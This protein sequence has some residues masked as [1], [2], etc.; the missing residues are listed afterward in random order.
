MDDK[1]KNDD[2]IRPLSPEEIKAIGEIE[3]GP[4][5]HEL[6]LNAHYKKLLWC[7]IALS[8]GAGS[9]IAWFSY[10]NDHR[11]AA[12]AQVINVFNTSAPG[13]AAAPGA[14]SKD[15]L[16]ALQQNYS[17]TPSAATGKLLAALSDLQG[18][19]AEAALAA[20]QQIADSAES[21]LIAARAQVAVANYY[22]NNSKDKEASAAWQKLVQMGDSPYL[23]LAYL[24]LGDLASAAG[25]KKAARTYYESARSKC[26][27]SSLVAGSDKVVEMRLLLLDVDAPK[28]VAPAPKADSKAGDPLDPFG[29]AAE[30]ETPPAAPAADPF[31][32]APAQ[33]GEGPLGPVTP[34]L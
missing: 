33:P 23:A 30:A 22:M 29:D 26:E 14:Y 13:S 16:Q 7:G 21:P 11:A 8:L 24:S 34:A 28:P 27:T 5:K 32:P 17:D 4:S 31:G 2:D 12:S 9:V 1:T 19:K 6:F 10:R 3:I 18:D 20:L 25:D 15:A